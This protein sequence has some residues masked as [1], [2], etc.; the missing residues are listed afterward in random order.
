MASAMPDS[1]IRSRHGYDDSFEEAG[2]IKPSLVHP[3][4]L[5]V[6]NEGSTTRDYLGEY[7]CKLEVQRLHLISCPLQ[8]SSATIWPG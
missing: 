3:A 7:G 1:A 6:R 5:V 4:Q 2:H 8:L